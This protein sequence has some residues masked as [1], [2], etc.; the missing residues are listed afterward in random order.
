MARMLSIKDQP[1]RAPTGAS[2]GPGDAPGGRLILIRATAAECTDRRILELCGAYGLSP[3]AATL[4]GRGDDGLVVAIEV[5]A[6]TAAGSAMLE[7]ELRALPGVHSVT[8]TE[9]GVAARSNAA[10]H[11]A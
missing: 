4:A 5:P 9:V 11:R 8:V 1:E 3:Q 10:Q 6:S 2:I 7:T